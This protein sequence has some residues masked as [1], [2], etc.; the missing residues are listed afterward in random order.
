MLIR[1]GPQASR[2]PKMARILRPKV[3]R[4]ATLGSSAFPGRAAEPGHEKGNR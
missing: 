3:P 1:D 4:I 2:I